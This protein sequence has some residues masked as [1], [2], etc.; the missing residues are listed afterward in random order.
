[1]EYNTAQKIQ[2]NNHNSQYI[3]S[4]HNTTDKEDNTTQNTCRALNPLAV[5][6]TQSTTYTAQCAGSS[7]NKLHDLHHITRE[8]TMHY[9]HTAHTPQQ[10]R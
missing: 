5:V 2:Y 7:T 1:M 4:Q 6:Q 3:H 9:L 8:D 10:N